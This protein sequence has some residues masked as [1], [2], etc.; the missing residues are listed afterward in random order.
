[1]PS[2]VGFELI[3]VG[4]L[5]AILVASVVVA[6]LRGSEGGPTTAEAERAEEPPPSE[7]LGKVVSTRFRWGQHPEDDWQQ[8]EMILIGND[9]S[10]RT[11]HRIVSS[12]QDRLQP[13]QDPQS[14]MVEEVARI[15][16]PDASLA[17]PG[18]LAV[19]M[20]VGAAGSGKTTVVG[21]LAHRLV[22]KGRLVAV[23]AGGTFGAEDFL[24]LAAWA[25]R[26]G[27]DLVADEPGIDRA[28]AAYGA[29]EAARA[30]GSDVLIV[31]T[32][33]GT[34]DD[35]TF[36]DGL[37]KIGRVLEK[38]AGRVDETLLV[39]DASLDQ[40][41]IPHARSFIDALGVTGIALSKFDER[42]K[43]GIVLTVREELGIPV[44]LVTTGENVVD[45]RA[46]DANWFARILV[47]DERVW[48]S[49]PSRDSARAASGEP[50][51]A[52]ES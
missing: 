27:A 44:K 20:V 23:A 7:S 33:G 35:N 31:D 36:T 29:V 41:G 16:G 46:F 15:L 48:A 52:A 30:R 1:V 26:A 34:L 13:G 6:R 43:A 11:A 32:A 17:L 37:A 47:G 38:A 4:A 21:R 10:P 3:V 12:L 39:L 40:S 19:V 49:V 51:S 2:G 18:P 14:L 9:L 24:E 22:N 45:L 25:D 28:A 50:I 42:E 8:L 5:M